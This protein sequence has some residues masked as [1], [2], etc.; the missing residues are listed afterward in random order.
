MTLKTRMFMAMVI[1]TIAATSS[2]LDFFGG[3]YEESFWA[4]AASYYAIM[5]WK[6]L[7]F[8]A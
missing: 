1:A 7:N 3:A 5:F 8:Y 6:E 2:V 4:G